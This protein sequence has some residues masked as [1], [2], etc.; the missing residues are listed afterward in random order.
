M[1]NAPTATATFE[2]HLFLL[3]AASICVAGAGGR[4]CSSEFYST[5]R[6]NPK[7]QIPSTQ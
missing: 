2:N 7:F 3:I 4:H 1:T 6:I 5:L